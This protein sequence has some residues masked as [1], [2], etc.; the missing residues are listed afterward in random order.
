MCLN[1]GEWEAVGSH[2]RTSK[3]VEEQVGQVD[4]IAQGAKTKSFLA[5]ERRE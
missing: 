5:G 2:A 3:S 1:D 4:K